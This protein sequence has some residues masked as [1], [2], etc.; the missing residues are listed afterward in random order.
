MNSKK[1]RPFV[2]TVIM[3]VCMAALLMTDVGLLFGQEGTRSRQTEIEDQRFLYEYIYF[4]TDSTE[5]LPLSMGVLDRKV[6]WLK[7]NPQRSVIIEGYCDERG[8]EE[9]NL[10]LGEARAGRIK[11]Y[12]IRNGIQASRLLTISYGEEDPV[13]PGRNEEAWSKNRRVRFVIQ[14]NKTER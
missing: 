3:G 9:F 8:S 13:D 7:Q 1:D 12:L 4:K 14:Q 5:I 6:A 11:T 10:L 2:N